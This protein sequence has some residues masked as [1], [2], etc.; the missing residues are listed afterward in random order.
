MDCDGL[1]EVAAELALGVLTGRER[2]QAIMHLDGCGTCREHIRRLALTEED[3]LGL[4]PGR[5]PPAGFE[6]GVMG[7]IGFTGRHRRRPPR[8][9]RWMLAAAACHDHRGGGRA[10]RL[11]PARRRGFTPAGSVAQPALH[12]AALT[13]ASD[14]PIGRVFLYTGRPGWL[15]MTVDTGSGNGT[16]I[17]Q[18]EGRDGRGITV[19][20]FRLTG[21]YGPWGSP[22]PL[23]PAAVTGARLATAG[24]KAL[25]TASF[26]PPG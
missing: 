12:A 26:S 3:L 23:P 6:T 21:G 4:L 24:G 9:P 19:G 2:A 1:A 11:G 22:E 18:L 15:Y 20:S 14:Q 7:R 25:A 16:L 17:C 8:R 10:G 5:G 13:T